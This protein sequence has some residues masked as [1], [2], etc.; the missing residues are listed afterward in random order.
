MATMVVKLRF[1]REI[2]VEYSNFNQVVKGSRLSKTVAFAIRERFRVSTDFL[3]C[4]DREGLSVALDK[5]LSDWERKT[6][7]SLPRTGPV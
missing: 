3:W 7:I 1:A 5:Q 6:G 2:G 4:G